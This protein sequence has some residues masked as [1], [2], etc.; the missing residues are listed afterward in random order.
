MVI[1]S[2][3]ATCFFFLLLLVLLLLHLS[4]RYQGLPCQQC[5]SNHTTNFMALKNNHSFFRILL[6]GK[7]SMEWPNIILFC[8]SCIDTFNPAEGLVWGIPVDLVYKPGDLLGTRW[9]CPWPLCVTF[10][11]WHSEHVWT[12][13]S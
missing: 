3:N 4:P 8:P 2:V 1:L 10:P 7:L 6:N 11:V 12:S 5:V 9:K 13:Y